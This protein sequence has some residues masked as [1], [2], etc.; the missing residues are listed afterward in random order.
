MSTHQISGPSLVQKGA[1]ACFTCAAAK[2]RCSGDLPA[3]QRCQQRSQYPCRY[4]GM[5]EHD[6]EQ[7]NPEVDHTQ[8]NDAMVFQDTA[9]LVQHDNEQHSSDLGAQVVIQGQG[10]TEDEGI[11]HFDQ[12]CWDPSMLS[13]INWLGNDNHMYSFGALM[14]SPDANY[15]FDLQNFVQTTENGHIHPYPDAMAVS[16]MYIATAD[17]MHEARQGAHSSP[18]MS[19]TSDHTPQTLQ[20]Q[21][22]T[23]DGS[24]RE[25]EF[26]VDGQAA[27]LPRAKRRRLTLTVSPDIVTNE[28]EGFTLDIIIPVA[29]SQDGTE[30]IKISDDVYQSLIYAFDCVCT[31]ATAH[32]AGIIHDGTHELMETWDRVPSSFFS[33]Y[34]S[35]GF[36]SKVVFEKLIQLY[37]ESIHPLLPILHETHL[38]KLSWQLILVV[39]AIGARFFPI[40]R[41]GTLVASLNEFVR[42]VLFV[43]IENS[44]W[45]PSSKL[46]QAQMR[47]LHIIS[48]MYSGI[49]TQ[50]GNKHSIPQDLADFFFTA[51]SVSANT[52]PASE[53][54]QWSH[55]I[56]QETYRRTSYAV[57]QLDCMCVIH[58]QQEAR[59][60]LEDPTLS[61]PCHE[62]L[63]A[64][65]SC[66]EWKNLSAKYPEVG[67]LN[68][69][70]QRLYVEK[71]L[72]P[73]TGEFSRI[74]LIHGLFR[75]LWEVES[76]L[77]HP[78]SQWTPTAQKQSA[79]ALAKS[80]PVWLPSIP[81]YSQWRNSACDCLDI[82]HWSANAS[83]GT[84]SGIEHPTVLHLHFARVVLLTPHKQIVTLAKHLANIEHSDKSNQQNQII[85]RWALQD[86]YKARL[87]MIHAG[88]L[89]WHIR[90]YSASGFYE[91]ASLAI[92]TLTLWAFSAFSDPTRLSNGVEPTS[93]ETSSNQENP[94][95][96]DSV[97]DI[98]LLD[99]PTDDE[100]VQQFVREGHKM[101][102]N[103]NGVGDLYGK[104][105]PERVLV[106]G[107]KLLLGLSSWGDSMIWVRILDG[108]IKISKQQRLQESNPLRG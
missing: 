76:Y 43:S 24:H 21:S 30:D 12:T 86:Q 99:R 80:S 106:E 66:E 41:V 65:S 78:L 50:N 25:G 97:C 73:V 100:L 11:S 17:M 58:F 84:A 64:A 104:H 87:A 69:A 57:W 94:G 26:Y 47:L 101:R 102:A 82:L 16:P 36:P 52:S 103:M 4:P 53:Q 40:E 77:K 19:Q 49:R 7:P 39:S 42:R 45:L 90:R 5:P 85:R 33:S 105:G 3:C 8:A 63:W 95:E 44:K 74:L 70:L 71:T 54:D 67:S 79:E 14:E 10:I 61:L 46:E 89:F 59:F 98:I 96:E 48:C 72:L 91:P 13:T 108:L 83:I 75:R 35:G 31:E 9:H 38:G 6:I 55:W 23:G 62:S 22:T 93:R 51:Q 29:I 32:R 1:R 15:P 27:R 28:G 60:K 81:T 20:S 2:V 88:V 56:E 68:S 37:V 34:F 107:R 18:G 92:A